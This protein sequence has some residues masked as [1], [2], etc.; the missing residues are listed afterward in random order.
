MEIKGSSSLGLVDLTEVHKLQIVCNS[1]ILAK[2]QNQTVSKTNDKF[3]LFLK[4][5]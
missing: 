5:V 4:R 3:E 1:V 2:D